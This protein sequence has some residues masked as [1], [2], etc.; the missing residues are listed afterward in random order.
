MSDAVIDAKCT[1]IV[2]IVKK[3]RMRI[4][5]WLSKREGSLV[6]HANI[7]VQETMRKLIHFS[8]H[9]TLCCGFIVIPICK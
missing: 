5:G 2:I 1:E 7:L 8:A 9:C 6:A 3:L 4:D